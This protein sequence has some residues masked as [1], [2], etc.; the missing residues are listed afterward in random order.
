MANQITGN[1][2]NMTDAI[3]RQSEKIKSGG[4]GISNTKTNGI[5]GNSFQE[6]LNRQLA[7]EISFSKH[8]SLRSE[9]RNIQMTQADMAKLNEACDKANQKGIKEALIISDKAAFIVN[10]QSK[11]VVTVVDKSEMKDNVFTNIDG[12]LFL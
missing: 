2:Y 5:A 12:A 10:A 6:I 7:N 9:E 11:V 4:S 8:A 1:N 3:I